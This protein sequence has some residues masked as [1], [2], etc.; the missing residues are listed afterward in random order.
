MCAI[1]YFAFVVR[2]VVDDIY[3]FYRWCSQILNMRAIPPV[4]GSLGRRCTYPSSYNAKSVWY[5][6]ELCFPL[7]AMVWR[8]KWR[9][10]DVELWWSGVNEYER[11]EWRVQVSMARDEISAVDVGLER[12]NEV[13]VR[14]FTLLLLSEQLL[15]IFIYLIYLFISTAHT[16]YFY[17]TTK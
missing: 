17:I 16:I 7:S 6:R 3:L 9:E 1:F 11:S 5:A 12:G 15:M 14:Y 13:C 4:H 8:L 2:T 10:R